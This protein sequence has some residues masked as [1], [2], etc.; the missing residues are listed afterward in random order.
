[1]P[2]GGRSAPAAP[3]LAAA[4][5]DWLI[6]STGPSGRIARGIPP[7]ILRRTDQEGTIVLDL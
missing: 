4:R 6:A 5:A 1:L 7:G 3:L 2:E